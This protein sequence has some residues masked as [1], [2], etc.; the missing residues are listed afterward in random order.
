MQRTCK[1][2]KK[3]KVLIKHYNT[4]EFQQC[5]CVCFVLPIYHYRWCWI[6]RVVCTPSETLLEKTQLPFVSRYQLDIA[7]MLTMWVVPTSS[8][9]AG[10]PTGP[11]PL[12]ALYMLPQY[13]WGHLCISP[14]V[15][16]ENMFLCYRN[17]NS[18]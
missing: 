8:L 9:C 16:V 14:A 7:S 13:L 12:Q 5:H 6:V 4:E 15:I 1:F 10:S 17:L 3:E 11:E 18:A 2:R